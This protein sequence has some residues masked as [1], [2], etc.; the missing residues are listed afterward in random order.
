[1]SDQS[2]SGKGLGL[3]TGIRGFTMIELLIAISLSAAFAAGILAI[4]S[5]NTQNFHMVNAMSQVQDDGR[6]ITDVLNRELRRDA[7]KSDPGNDPS[8]ANG[9]GFRR[10]VFEAEPSLTSLVANA[11]NPNIPVFAQGEYIKGASD[12]GGVLNGTPDSFMIRYQVDG[13]NDLNATLCGTGLNYDYSG[14]PQGNVLVVGIYVTATGVLECN[15]KLKLADLNGDHVYQDAE[16]Q[17]LPRP[18]SLIS[19]VENLRVLYG[20]DKDNDAAADQYVDAN[21]VANWTQIVSVRLV[22]VVRSTETN[23][24][25][26]RF[27]DCQTG[28]ASN[29][30]NYCINGNKIDLAQAASDQRRLYQVFSTTVALRN[31][32]L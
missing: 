31:K 9:L 32:V 19:N 18:V 30:A 28:A 27:L 2:I 5:N 20:V 13:Q 23:V 26:G 21:Q 10:Y 11:N 16:Y 1:M 3:W 15:A 25:T 8:S 24:V 29:V 4:M 22:V 17:Y 12:N 14:D 7:Y 6:Y